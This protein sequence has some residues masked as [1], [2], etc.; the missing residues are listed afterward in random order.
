MKSTFL[1]FL[2]ILISNLALAQSNLNGRI[3]DKADNTPLTNATIILLNQDSILKYHTRANENGNFEFKKINQEDYILIVSYPQFELYSQPVKLNKNTTLENIL[4]SSQANL[5]EEVVVT[6]KIPIRIKGDTIEYDAGSFETEKNAKLEDLL[7]RLPGLTVS[8]EGAITAHGKSVSKVLIDGEEFFGYDPKIAIRNIRADAVDKVQVY[9]RKS[10]QAELTGI[11]DGQRFQTV[12]VLLKEEARVGIFGNVEGHVGTEELYT[13]NLFAAKFNRTERIGI[14]ANTNNMGASSG[15]REGSLRMNSQITGEPKNTSVGANYENQ[16]FNKKVNVN[17][18][19][20]FNDAS[21][22]N[23]RESYNK[24]IVSADKIQETNSTSNNENA[25]QSHNIR[26]Q[27]RWRIDSTSNMEVHVNA[28]KSQN[29]GFSGSK[30]L[31][32][33]NETDSVRDYNSTNSNFGDDLSNEIRINYRKRLNKNGRSINLNLNNEI[34]Q[35]NQ[36]SDV[37]QR[38][39]LYETNRETIVDQNRFTDNNR[40]NFSTQLQFSDR[41][42]QQLHFTLGYNFGYN[43]NTNKVDAFN[44]TATGRTLDEQYSQNL[45]NKT[46]NQSVVANLNYNAEKFNF[47]LSNRTNYRDQ[48]LNDSYHDIDLDRTFWDN[49]LNIN[50]NYKISNRKN[51]NAS[52]QNNFDVPSFSQL[53]PTQPQTSPIFV[54][55]GNPNLKRAV[56]NSFRLNY[57]TMSLLKGTSWNINSSIAF[58]NNPIVNKRTVTDTLTTSTYVNVMGKT[59]WNASLNTNYGKPIFDRKV[60]FNIFSGANYTNG[61][62]YTRYSQDGSRDNQGQYELNNTQNASILTGFSFNEQDSKGLDYDFNWRVNANNQRNSLQQDLNYTNLSTGG[63]AFLKYFLPKQFNIT[64]HI[65]YSIEGATKLYK[66][67]IQQFYTNVELSKKLLKNQSLVASIKAF[68]IFKTYNTTNRN[69]SD[70]QFSESTQLM[71]TRYVLFG[72]KW[73][74]NKNLGKK[75][76]D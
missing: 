30:S 56:N 54:Q 33:N 2:G 28:N 26:S 68:D 37:F 75:S 27:F 39:Y 51:I 34:S 71:L 8:G 20:N 25:N 46:S 42:T 57:N 17:A 11:D 12:N 9:E 31:M 38:T 44:N 21:N 15:G 59:S 6:G 58:K 35:S 40:N 76:N 22:R 41:I 23:E 62:T 4:L 36:E 52:Y 24:E 65:N 7:R 74:F 61:F 70:T 50:G 3:L 29:T 47:S 67:S 19:Y 55:E 10:E 72:L 18:N 49:D 1:F 16:L 45:I 53:Q 69:V 48:S 63:S 43:N 14:T 73:D 66:E 32:L 5:I 60:Q 13:A 64:T